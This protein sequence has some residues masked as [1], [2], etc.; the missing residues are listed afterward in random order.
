MDKAGDN[1]V[2]HANRTTETARAASKTALLGLEIIVGA[3]LDALSA[4]AGAE[5]LRTHGQRYHD[6]MQD[7]MRWL[8]KCIMVE[9]W[10]TRRQAGRKPSS[11]PGVSSRLRV[12][13]R[14]C[15]SGCVRAFMCRRARE[16]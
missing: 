14:V 4:P 8:R 10:T 15:L 7:A 2:Q 16:A 9:P 12:T 13:L 6:A 3:V 5:D 1:H 11:G